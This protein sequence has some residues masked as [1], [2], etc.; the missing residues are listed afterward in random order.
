M[1]DESKG[2]MIPLTKRPAWKA[3]KAHQKKI[4]SLHLRKLFDADPKRG[5]RMTVEAAGLFLDY[6]KNRIVDQTIT[7]LQRLAN[8]SCLRERIDAMFSGNKINIT[9]N[10]RFRRRPDGFLGAARQVPGK[11]NYTR[12][13]RGR[14]CAPVPAVCRYF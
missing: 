8:Q 6:S 9:E 2:G 7:L 10:H 11:E 1:G 12:S 4:K 3:L 13:S 5:Q 14:D